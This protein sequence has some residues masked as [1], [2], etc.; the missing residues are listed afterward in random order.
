MFYVFHNKQLLFQVDKLPSTLPD[1]TYILSNS[2]LMWLYKH[3]HRSYR[4]IAQK[5][6]PKEI[7]LLCLLLNIPFRS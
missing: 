4:L 2:G 3:K 6:V 7:K 5:H 1:D